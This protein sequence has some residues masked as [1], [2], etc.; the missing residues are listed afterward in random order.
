VLF[1]SDK[2]DKERWRRATA[3]FT[4]YPLLT[5]YNLVL[6]AAETAIHP[7]PD[8]LSAAKLRFAGDYWVFAAVWTGVLVLSCFGSGHDT[9]TPA[10]HFAVRRKW[11]SALLIVSVSLTLTSGVCFGAGS[12][13]RIPLE[14]SVPLLAASGL[15]RLIFSSREL[16]FSLISSQR[17]LPTLQK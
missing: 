11:L 2:A 10:E 12:R 9:D 17:K 15:W 16:S 14:L 8:V 1:R 7:S 6:G 3:V 13:Y 4:E 5:L